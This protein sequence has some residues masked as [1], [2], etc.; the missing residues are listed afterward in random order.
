MADFT[1]TQHSNLVVL[2]PL[3]QA[4]HEWCDEHLPEDRQRWAGGS[5][6]EARYFGDIYHGIQSD[7]L[8]VDR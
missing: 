8:T 4:A 5:V 6:I 3:S 2:V 7:G 1:F